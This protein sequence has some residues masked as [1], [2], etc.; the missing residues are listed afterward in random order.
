MMGITQSAARVRSPG[1]R[2][3][4]AY[5]KA[6]NNQSSGIQAMPRYW[7]LAQKSL[8]SRVWTPSSIIPPKHQ[9]ADM[10][11]SVASASRPAA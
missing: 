7:T 3:P 10:T 5:R 8:S 9:M 1:L 4:L 11:P 2:P 6:N